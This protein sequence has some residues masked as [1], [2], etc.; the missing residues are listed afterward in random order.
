MRQHAI[1]QNI[2][3]VEFKLFTRF[4]LKEFAYLAAGI[5]FGGIFLYLVGK[6]LFPGV[7]GIPIFVIT[8]LSG[9]ILA[10]VPINDQNA[11][12]F[13][14]NYV[15]AINKPTQRVWL[16][17]EM[18]E[19]RVKPDVKPGED[20]SLIQKGLK[21]TKK[22]IIGGNLL[23]L[24]KK[25]EPKEKTFKEKKLPQT[26][27]EQKPKPINPTVIQINDQNI[28]NYQ[29]DI[30]S[31]KQLPGNINIWLSTKELKPVPNVVTYLRDQNGKTL[32]AN[33]TGP[34][35]YFLTNKEWE[36][37]IYSIE[38]QHTQYKFPKVQLVLTK[39]MDKKP[40]K[41]TTI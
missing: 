26:I 6:G 29:I 38:F 13:I 19:E 7:I 5:G 2:L 22:K 11:D 17:K 34:N 36:Q 18:K 28:T 10:L 35:G 14:K 8:S 40:I 33:K 41:I 3:D 37:G 20:G 31:L 12:V 1:P 39:N 4:T 25:E 23:G 16:N 30:K 32:Y 27:E 21:E 15:T 24:E 9:I